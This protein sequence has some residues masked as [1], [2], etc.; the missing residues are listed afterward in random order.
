M[1]L[2]K[3]DTSAPTTLLSGGAVKVKS[4][5]AEENTSHVIERLTKLYSNPVEAAVREAYSNAYD[6]TVALP[7][8]D[9]KPIRLTSPSIFQP[10]FI[11]QDRGTG[12]SLKTV[13]EVYVNY[14][15]STKGDDLDAVGSHGLGGKAPLAYTNHFTVET[16][17]D[18]VTT[19][20]TMERSGGN[21]ETTI[22]SSEFTGKESGT[23]VTIPVAE[24]DVDKF[25]AA[26]DIYRENSWNLP[27]IIDGVEYFGSSAYLTFGTVPVYEDEE[28]KLKGE[29][30]I[31]RSMIARYFNLLS[32]SSDFKPNVGYT[33]GGWLYPSDGQPIS[34]VSTDDKNPLFK[35]EIPPAVVEFSSS[36]DSITSNMKLTMLNSLVQQATSTEA[37]FIKV[38]SAMNA[39]TRDDIATFED[40]IR[41]PDLRVDLNDGNGKVV[42]RR[43]WQGKFYADLEKF[44]TPELELTSLYGRKEVN[45]I[46]SFFRW[47]E[48]A[49]E[50]LQLGAIGPAKFYL[51]KVTFNGIKRISAVT[52]NYAPQFDLVQI[53]WAH[54]GSERELVLVMETD[55]QLFKRLVR[56]R[57]ALFS[58]SRAENVYL[59]S[60]EVFG[61][62]PEADQAMVKRLLGDRFTTTNAATLLREIAPDIKR[63]NSEKR[64]LRSTEPTDKSAIDLRFYGT[65]LECSLEEPTP[66]EFLKNIS[67][68]RRSLQLADIAAED[69]VVFV[70]ANWRNAFIGAVNAGQ[71][72][73][74]RP[75]Y[76]FTDHLSAQAAKEL[77]K[78]KESV[79]FSGQPRVSHKAGLKLAEGQIFSSDV[80][81]EDLYSYS[82]EEL[83]ASIL[84]SLGYQFSSTALSFLLELSERDSLARELFDLLSR[85]KSREVKSNVG[86]HNAHEELVRRGKENRILQIKNFTRLFHDFTGST[87][88]GRVH[89]QVLTST[90]GSSFIVKD[91]PTVLFILNRFLGLVND[92]A[93]NTPEH[94]ETSV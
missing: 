91:D 72:I 83:E 15:A 18:G 70:G 59:F 84:L 55:Y 92:E 66:S 80:L 2:T 49:S 43:G 11:V 24:K 86:Q 36:R 28:V 81:N 38:A 61:K 4:H 48:N 82:D 79:F 45:S 44:D 39:L 60:Y 87:G 37:Y 10:E 21:V 29:I 27:T 56:N 5:I 31:N 22:H 17:C 33:I 26:I 41:A 35:V 7:V 16:T 71:R 93:L 51:P 25:A 47:S 32:S 58:G 77:G 89:A 34:D 85:L 54:Y 68:N 53:A 46:T 19:R 63:I 20:F 23:I 13:T 73:A 50:K 75:V 57:E 1:A 69:G 67:E 62:L 94:V 52:D 14:G 9:R 90:H 65:Q 76:V 3:R 78:I 64:A 88:A 12:M 8:S 40:T 42:L 74:G 6:A 30:R